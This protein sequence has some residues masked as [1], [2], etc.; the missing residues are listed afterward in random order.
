MLE[1]SIDNLQKKIKSKYTIVT[2]SAKRAR[3]LDNEGPVQLEEPYSHTSV[4]V[5]LEEINEGKLFVK[6][7]E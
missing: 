6:E 3:D 1:P 2:I 5:A 4:G 7:A